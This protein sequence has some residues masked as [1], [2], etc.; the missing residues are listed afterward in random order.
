M[1]GVLL[2]TSGAVCWLFGSHFIV[3]QDAVRVSHLLR[4]ISCPSPWFP[5]EPELCINILYSSRGSTFFYK[6]MVKQ[7]SCG[8]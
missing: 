2:S 3:V 4:L 5:F 8:G 1:L 7:C 6:G